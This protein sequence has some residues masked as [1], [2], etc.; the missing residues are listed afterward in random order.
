MNTLH[1]LFVMVSLFNQP[2]N[3]TMKTLF[4]LYKKVFSPTMYDIYSLLFGVSQYNFYYQCK[5]NVLCLFIYFSPLRLQTPPN[6]FCLYHLRNDKLFIFPYRSV[7]RPM[8]TQALYVKILPRGHTSDSVLRLGK[9]LHFLSHTSVSQ[10]L[11]IKDYCIFFSN[12]RSRPVE[13]EAGRQPTGVRSGCAQLSKQG[14]T[15]KITGVSCFLVREGVKS[16]E[17]ALF[18]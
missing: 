11:P 12:G 1:R 16:M 4:V 9:M 13:P 3:E 17:R 8:V 10:I 7:S 14:S 18:I 5:S 15:L 6:Q 2:V